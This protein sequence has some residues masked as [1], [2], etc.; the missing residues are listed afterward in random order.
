MDADFSKFDRVRSAI[1]AQTHGQLILNSLFDP[2][3]W[4]D[5]V[6]KLLVDCSDTIK[7]Q[8]PARNIGLQWHYLKSMSF[9]HGGV[10]Q[11]EHEEIVYKDVGEHIYCIA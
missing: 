9:E 2:S 10:L 6:P 4:T 8:R 1:V 3:L 11:L 5:F 7:H